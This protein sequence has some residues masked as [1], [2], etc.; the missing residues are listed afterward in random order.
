MQKN[1]AAENIVKKM[2]PIHAFYKRTANKHNTKK[3][4]PGVQS[5]TNKKSEK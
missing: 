1:Y 3:G 2:A 5:I 4:I